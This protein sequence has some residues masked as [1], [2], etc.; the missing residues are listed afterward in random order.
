[1]TME[2]SKSS[3]SSLECV[4][5][6]SHPDGAISVRSTLAQ[7]GPTLEFTADEWAAFAAGMKSGVFDFGLDIDTLLTRS[8]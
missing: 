8:R 4:E 7:D 1:M 2:Y 5:V 6:A 3:Y